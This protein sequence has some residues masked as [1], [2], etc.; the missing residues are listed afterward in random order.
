MD[1]RIALGQIRPRT[2]ASVRRQ[3]SP[4]PGGIQATFGPLFQQALQGQVKS[5]LHVSAHAEKR[6]QERNICL[7]AK[8]RDVLNTALDELQAKGARDSLVVTEDGAFVV[9]VPTRTLVTA[10][11]VREMRDRIVTQ[12]DSVSLKNS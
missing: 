8:M 2:A 11:D 4:P 12:I 9:N 1:P 3:D 5:G 10:M 7:D 6:L